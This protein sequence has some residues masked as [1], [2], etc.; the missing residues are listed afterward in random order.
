MAKDPLAGAR[1]LPSEYHPRSVVLNSDQ[2]GQHIVTDSSYGPEH[3]VYKGPDAQRA[4]E[5]QTS[6]QSVIKGA[7]TRRQNKRNVL[8][9]EETDKAGVTKSWLREKLSQHEA[10]AWLG[11]DFTAKDD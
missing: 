5:A 10:D 4:K 8:R 3:E 9:Q 1:Y 11:L 6:R 2:M 7:L